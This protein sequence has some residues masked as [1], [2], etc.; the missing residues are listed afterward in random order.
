MRDEPIL[1]VLKRTNIAKIQAVNTVERVEGSRILHWNDQ[2]EV[3]RTTY[4]GDK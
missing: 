4:T 1:W 2:W 3:M